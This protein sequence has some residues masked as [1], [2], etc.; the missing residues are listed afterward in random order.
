[1]NFQEQMQ[2]LRPEFQ[3]RFYKE[4][5]DE[6]DAL[7]FN[8][9]IPANYRLFALSFETPVSLQVKAEYFIWLQQ[10]AEIKEFNISDAITF[11]RAGERKLMEWIQFFGTSPA[12]A[13]DYAEYLKFVES[14]TETVNSVCEPLSEKLFR[15][16]SALQNL[17]LKNNNTRILA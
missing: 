7:V 6:W 11:C 14:V 8:T 10:Q 5:K 2:M 17:Q 15:K 13:K 4:Q 16:I 9:D 1:M 3:E 12:M